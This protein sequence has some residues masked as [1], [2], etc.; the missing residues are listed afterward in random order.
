[1][2][3]ARRWLSRWYLLLGAVAL[4]ACWRQNLEFMA[5]THVSLPEAFVTFW[6]ALLANHATT[7]ITID[8]SVLGLA[9]LT[10][11]ILEARR[12]GMRHVWIYIVLAFG[13]AISVT[14]P[15]FLA[16]RERRLDTLGEPAPTITVVDRLGIAALA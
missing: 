5:E 13:I 6:P 1:M 8:I 10:W 14:V 12:T 4:V 7:S 3:D 11:M 2:S 9:V 16:M 15:V